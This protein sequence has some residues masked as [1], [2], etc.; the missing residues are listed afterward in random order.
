MLGGLSQV[1][2]LRATGQRL[3]AARGGVGEH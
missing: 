1:A 2:V 3:A